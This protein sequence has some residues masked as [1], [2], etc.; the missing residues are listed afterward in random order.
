MNSRLATSYV[1]VTGRKNPV[2]HFSTRTEVAVQM[3][4]Q[5]IMP[6]TLDKDLAAVRA[7]GVLALIVKHIAYVAV[8]N[9][10]GERDSARLLQ[11]PC[12]RPGLVS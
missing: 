4:F 11:C 1:R 10:R 9:A 3:V 8:L 12:R 7:V 6:R 2:D 5:N